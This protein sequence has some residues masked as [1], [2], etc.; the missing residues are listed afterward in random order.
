MGEDISVSRLSEIFLELQSQGA[1]NINLV[2]PS[3]F[4]P[5]V[6]KALDAVREKILIPVVCNCSGYESF[7]ILQIF[8][9][10]V[11]VYLPDLK[12]FSSERSSRYSGA[13][14]YFQKASQSLAEMFRQTGP[15]LFSPSGILKRGL[16]IRHLVLPEGKE[17]S[18]NL[19]HWISETFPKHTVRVSLM[20]QYTPCG[21]LSCC[22]EINRPLFSIEYDKVLR[23]AER[24]DLLGY[25]QGRGCDDFKMTPSFDLTGV[26]KDCNL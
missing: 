9:G 4:A 22:P 21:D 24:L 19:L 16:L 17:D 14:D 11:D 18:I 7:E 15:C 1:E 10:L 25:F 8:D 12:Y 23:Y 5:F 3:H 20:R 6:A 13:G 26:R 2:T